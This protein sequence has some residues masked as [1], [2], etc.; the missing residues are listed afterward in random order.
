MCGPIALASRVRHGGRAGLS[1]F[2]GRLVSYSL[3]GSL[4]GGVG[5][6]LLLS[7]WARLAEAGLSWLLAATLTYTGW[8]LL[9]AAPRPRLSKLG[10]APRTSRIGALLVHL[11]D[12]PLLLG[13]ATALLPC[14]ALFSALVASATLGSAGYGALSLA[15]FAIITGAVV[16]G[17]GQLARLRGRLPGLKQVVGAALLI[18]AAITAY[19]PVPMLRADSG[20]P[21]CHL[22][23]HAARAA[24]GDR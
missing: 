18:G 16:V 24:Q 2:A 19:R 21:V 10:R 13:A 23:G 8:S 1:Y 22:P 7:S 6:V 12:D 14:A 17:V 20:V 3:L 11:A 15:T 5:R 4:A 9:R